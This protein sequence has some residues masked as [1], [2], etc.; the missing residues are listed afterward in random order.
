MSAAVGLFGDFYEVAAEAVIDGQRMGRSLQ[1]AVEVLRQADFDI[2][3][4]CERELAKGFERQMGQPP[5]IVYWRVPR[6]D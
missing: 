6:G 5:E 1:V 4:Y 2:A 3:E